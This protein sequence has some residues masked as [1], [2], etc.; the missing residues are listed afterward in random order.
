M[1]FLHA[2]LRNTVNVL[3][4]SN[5]GD[6]MRLV[7]I[8]V[9]LETKASIRLNWSEWTNLIRHIPTPKLTVERKLRAV[10]SQTSLLLSCR[11]RPRK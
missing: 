2:M 9:P 7:V 10:F 3:D 8:S 4:E 11:L 1:A 5:F 6:S